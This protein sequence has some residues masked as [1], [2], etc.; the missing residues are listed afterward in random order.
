MDEERDCSPG[1]SEAGSWR[2]R[3]ELPSPGLESPRAQGETCPL[4][5]RLSGHAV[6]SSQPTAAPYSCLVTS[7]QSLP[8]SELVFLSRKEMPHLGKEAVRQ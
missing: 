3:H 8:S 5:S 7:G 1:L 2:W 4:S 6:L